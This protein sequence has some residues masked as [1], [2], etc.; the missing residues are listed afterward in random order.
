MRTWIRQISSHKGR[1]YELFY[2]LSK[3]TD[4]MGNGK[5][6]QWIDDKEYECWS[7]WVNK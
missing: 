7:K 4:W 1:M 6:K 2:W 3:S 5:L